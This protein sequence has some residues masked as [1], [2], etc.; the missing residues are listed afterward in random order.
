MT[1]LEDRL[2]AE[3]LMLRDL[4]A[5]RD[6]RIASLERMLLELGRG[7]DLERRPEVKSWPA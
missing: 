7:S 6:E 1:D 3:I 5:R 2:R 4:I